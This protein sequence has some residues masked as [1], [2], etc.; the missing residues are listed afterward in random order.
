ML[1]GMPW[2]P[3]WCPICETVVHPEQGIFL[4]DEG[5]G[6][7]AVS[8]Q[9]TGVV[10]GGASGATV[11]RGVTVDGRNRHRDGNPKVQVPCP[12]GH[13]DVVLLPGYLEIRDAVVALVDAAQWDKSRQ[14]RV[15]AAAHVA[16]TTVDAAP[17][18]TVAAVARVDA[19]TGVALSRILSKYGKP[20]LKAASG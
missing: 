20:G 7:V 3:A 12:E 15:V 18:A 2:L 14:E 10:L 8:Q 16:V 4:P 19:P 5:V 17:D 1:R 13:G 11:V 9:G 6:H